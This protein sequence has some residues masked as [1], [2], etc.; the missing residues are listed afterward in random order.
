MRNQTKIFLLI[1]TF[2][3]FLLES[4]AQNISVENDSTVEYYIQNILLGQGINTSNIQFNG[5]AANVVNEQVGL[6]RDDSSYTGLDFGLILGSG[7]VTLAEQSNTSGGA[8]A[9]G[10]GSIGSD[11]DLQS[12]TPNTIW[13]ECV[14]EFDFVPSGNVLSFNYKFA[15]EEYDEYV[16]G[17]VNDAFGF[18]LTGA[19]PSGG[20]YGNQNVALVPNPND[21]TQYTNTPVSIN[22]VNNGTSGSGSTT[23][24]DN[25]DPNWTSYSIFYESNTTNA[26]QYDGGTVVL[27]ITIPVICDS[28]YHI[29]L[30]IGDGGDGLWDSGVF[31]EGNSFSAAGGVEVASGISGGDQILYEGCNNAFFTFTRTEAP[32]DYTLY[33]DVVGSAENGVDYEEVQDSVVLGVGVLSDTLYINPIEDFVDE[34]TETIVVQIVFPGCNGNDTL[35]AELELND[36]DP[37]IVSIPDSSNICTAFGEEVELEAI[38][39]GGLGTKTYEWSSGETDSIITVAPGTTTIYFVEVND[40]CDQSVRSNEGKVWV[41][42]PIEGTN[43]FT[44]NND[45]NNDFFIPENTDQYGTVRLEIFNRWGTLVYLSENYENDWNGTHYKTGKPLADG[46]YYYIV[47]PASIKYEYDEKEKRQYQISGYVHIM[48]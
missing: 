34:S 10:S 41:Q 32:D 4:K 20:D 8:S 24:C 37:I 45:G 14:I 22:T 47:T 44:P 2:F 23:N 31:L 19:N 15:S 40:I 39:T 21:P 11:P 7:D 5:G 29:K 38:A 6:F 1:V 13:D 28:T 25:I 9:G 3:C 17:S 42:C 27:N 16:C 26:Y 43:V 46:V 36:Y 48:H 35:N 30:A 12:I 33:F 18:F